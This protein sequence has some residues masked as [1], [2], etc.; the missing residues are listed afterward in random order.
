MRAEPSWMGL[1]PYKRG[2]REIP[3]PFRY[4][5]TQTEGSSCEPGWGPSLEGDCAGPWSCTRSQIVYKLFSLWYFLSAA[6]VDWI[7]KHFPMGPGHTH[8]TGR[9]KWST[10]GACIWK[11]TFWREEQGERL[12]FPFFALVLSTLLLGKCE[13][14]VGKGEARIQMMIWKRYSLELCNAQPAQLH[15]VTMLAPTLSQFGRQVGS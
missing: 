11:R 6:R 2:S 10:M 5:C 9:M 14:P 4:A 1:L 7:R 8:S 13:W 15:M 3:C 12:E